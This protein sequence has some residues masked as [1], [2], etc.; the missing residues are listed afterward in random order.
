MSISFSEL[1]ALF[2]QVG[3]P[4]ADQFPNLLPQLVAYLE[5]LTQWNK[6]MNLVGK[7]TWQEI[8]CDLVADSIQLALFLKNH[9]AQN[10]TQQNKT[11]LQNAGKTTQKNKN[12]IQDIEKVIPQNEKSVQCC[13]KKQK[14]FRTFDLGAGAGLPGL[15]LRMLW[16]K[17][18]Y[19]LVESREKRALF[20]ATFLAKN[21]LPQTYVFRGRAEQILADPSKTPVALILSRAF[22]PWQEVLQL[23]RPALA[24]KGNVLF[25]LKE[26]LN[27]PP[28]Q[29]WRIVATKEYQIGSNTRFFFLLTPEQVSVSC[30]KNNTKTS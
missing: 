9:Y 22:M 5:M 4:S 12:T 28:C 15:V 25:M 16:Q 18:D 14:A 21:P 10:K 19:F 17:G 24:L 26:K 8:F 30:N 1:S 2:P 27:D 29:G 6:K 11:I 23:V 7:Q 3:L 13:E 20:L